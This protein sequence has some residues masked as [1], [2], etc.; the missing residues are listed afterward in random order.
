MSTKLIQLDCDEGSREDHQLRT[1]LIDS[2]THDFRT[3]LT[4]IK[5]AVTALLAGAQA[6]P[7][8]RAELLSI[9]DEE[10]DRLNRLVGNVVEVS[11][12]G[13]EVKLDLGRHTIASVIDVSRI[14]G[15]IR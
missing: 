7:S 6:R 9:I 3:P 2:V 12:L 13:C 14:L 5:A 4:S 8:Q 11:R 15:V 10:T 1:A